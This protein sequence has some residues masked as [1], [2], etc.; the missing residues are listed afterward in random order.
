MKKILTMIVAIALGT[1]IVTNQNAVETKAEGDY[2]YVSNEIGSIKEEYYSIPIGIQSRTA[3]LVEEGYT[4]IQANSSGFSITPRYFDAM[5]VADVTQ[6]PFCKVAQIVITWKDGTSSVATA[7]LIAPSAAAT[8]GHCVYDSEHG[9]WAEYIDVYVA[10]NRNTWSK[11]TSVTM[12]HT[13]TGWTQDASEDY[14]YAVLELSD[15]VGETCGYFGYTTSY[16][17]TIGKL[18]GY[19]TGISGY[20]NVQFKAGGTI[21]S[22]TDYAVWYNISARPGVSG[23]PVYQ[24]GGYAIAIH[25]G[26]TD[27]PNKGVRINTNVFNLFHSFR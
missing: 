19:L 9:G 27:G 20:D 5:L 11:K 24:D 17:G 22:Q 18:S 6:D 10:R 13:S 1:T 21:V 14:D 25:R 7:F 2:T 26:S 8:A 3:T 4:G 15:A 16:S 12:M 23:A